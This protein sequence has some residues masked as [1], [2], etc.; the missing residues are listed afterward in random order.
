MQQITIEVEDWKVCGSRDHWFNMIADG[1]CE[2]C[3]SA[4]ARL[5]APTDEEMD[6]MY[7]RSQTEHEAYAFAH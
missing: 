3:Q 4:F 2:R 7:K 1:R 5:P 6:A